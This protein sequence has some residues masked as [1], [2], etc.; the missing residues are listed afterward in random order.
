MKALVAYYS[1]SGNTKRMAEE[2]AGGLKAEGVQAEL[3]EVTKV[4]AGDLVNYEVIIFG[5]PTYYGTMAYEM[6]KL[7]DESVQWH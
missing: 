7:L 6:K 2:I 4:A 1:R 5:S 3:K